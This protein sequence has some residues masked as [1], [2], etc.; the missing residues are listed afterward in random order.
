MTNIR[1]THCIWN[2][3]NGLLWLADAADGPGYRLMGGHGCEGMP[4]V[5][6]GVSIE[7][8]ATADARMPWL[9]QT[10]AAIHFVSY[11]PLDAVDFRFDID[12]VPHGQYGEP[13]GLCGSYCDIAVGHVDHHTR[14]DLV[15]MGGESG[16]NARPCNISWLRS[17]VQ[18]CQ[19]A[20]VP[21]FVKQ[22]GNCSVGEC[23]VLDDSHEPVVC[24][25]LYHWRDRNGSDPH[26]WP[27]DLRVQEF[28]HEY[29]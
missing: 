16:P 9:L 14:L 24:N 15:I 28:P 25:V 8:Q 21:V 19:A 7:N 4:W 23:I 5:W 29:V 20:R 1:W 12:G 6:V 22:L 13:L 11:E 3:F 26:E 27:Y 2:P 18:Q 17:V 10:P